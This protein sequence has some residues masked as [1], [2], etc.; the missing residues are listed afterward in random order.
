[1]GVMRQTESEGNGRRYVVRIL[2]QRRGMKG[3][4][5]SKEKENQCG[6][7]VEEEPEAV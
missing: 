2:V 4:K 1:M 7:E 6:R 3:R 5:E